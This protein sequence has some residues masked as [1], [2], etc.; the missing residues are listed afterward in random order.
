MIDQNKQRERKKE[1]V[2]YNRILVTV[3]SEEPIVLLDKVLN[4]LALVR[5]VIDHVGHVVLRGSDERWT[6]HDRQV[7]RLHLNR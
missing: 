1:T 5:H 4:Y 6:Q 3:I 2:T 7:A